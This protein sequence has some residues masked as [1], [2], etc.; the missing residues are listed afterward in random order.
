LL[1]TAANVENY[2]SHGQEKYVKRELNCLSNEVGTL[3][4][5]ESKEIMNF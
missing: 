5:D 1:S 4:F 2:A 3:A